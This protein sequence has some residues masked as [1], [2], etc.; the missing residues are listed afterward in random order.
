MDAPAPPGEM[1][2]IGSRRLHCLRAGTGS[3]A[4][5]FESGGGGGSA[6]QD[7]VVQRLVALFAR[8]ILYDR[9]GLGWS[10]PAPPGRSFQERAGGLHALLRAVG[11]SPP[12]VLVGASFG[13]LTARA[14]SRRYP[15]EVVGM[16][17]V[18]AAE[19]EKYFPTMAGMRAWHEEEL[20]TEARRAASGELR[21]QAEPLVRKARGF[22]E[23]EKA[24]LLEILSRPGHFLAA[25]DELSAI[26]A[27]P[28]EMQVAGGFGRLGDMP[29][30]VLSADKPVT[31]D[32]AVWHEGAT[33]AQTRLAALSSNSEH[34]I[35]IGLGHS[36]ALERPALVAAA[37]A[38]VLKA[39][40]GA[41]RYH[42]GS[43][44]GRRPESQVLSAWT[45]KGVDLA[46]A[47][48]SMPTLGEFLDH[49]GAEG[50]QV[51]GFAR[52]HQAVVDHHLL[53]DPVGAG[54]AQIGLE[55][56]P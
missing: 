47:L 34:I 1:I 35:G 7:L 20:K 22:T 26:D 4:V 44:P 42:R 28:P 19:E 14:F 33:A 12:Y 3:P 8:A 39:A 15:D 54:I 27:T 46:R 56:G 49:P 16:V 37:I 24:W 32:M 17:L 29:Q 2:D 52:G 55:R 48:H 21:R 50:G 36:I 10:D 43:A 40:T 51:V 23:A 53:I 25:L 5:V 18:D 9:A 11:E 41:P 31:G 30:I 13:G 6:V 38:A 45:A